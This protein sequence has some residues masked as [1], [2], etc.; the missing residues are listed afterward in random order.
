MD[1]LLSLREEKHI[2]LDYIPNEHIIYINLETRKTFIKKHL[3]F[4]KV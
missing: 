1:S 2:C 4:S 3:T